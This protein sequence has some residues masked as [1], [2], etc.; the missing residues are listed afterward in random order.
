MS[1]TDPYE[2][3]EWPRGVLHDRAVEAMLDCAKG[4]A[5]YYEPGKYTGE[6]QLLYAGSRNGFHDDEMVKACFS[7]MIEGT[8]IAFD[9]LPYDIDRKVH[10]CFGDLP[11]QEHYLRCAQYIDWAFSRRE[12]PNLYDWDMSSY[13]CVR[14]P[15][16]SPLY[17]LPY[18]VDSEMNITQD[19]KDEKSFAAD[20][21][22]FVISPGRIEPIK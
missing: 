4:L 18:C 6:I 21:A 5:E 1:Y 12:E 15:Q 20:D 22:D 17:E 7:D 10:E 2:F 11:K 9:M 13:L 8:L 3:S 19:T 14:S 16:G